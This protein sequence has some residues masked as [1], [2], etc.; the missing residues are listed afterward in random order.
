MHRSSP[1][2]VSTVHP[3]GY[4]RYIS[5]IH[6]LV[7]SVR[8]V[9]Y[10][11]IYGI[12]EWNFAEIIMQYMYSTVQCHEYS[13]I[14]TVRVLYEHVP[15]YAYGVGDAHIGYDPVREYRYCSTD[16]AALYIVK[17]DWFSTVVYWNSVLRDPFPGH[18]SNLS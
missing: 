13:C 9:S 18:F 10:L 11:Y 12:Q 5:T 17:V 7:L 16:S 2:P 14:D 4:G 3:L 15:E 8:E 1:L 6:L